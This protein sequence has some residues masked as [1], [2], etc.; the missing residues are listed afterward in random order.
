MPWG[1]NMSDFYSNELNNVSFDQHNYTKYGL[2]Y[3][4]LLFQQDR[5][6]L[7]A[8]LLADWY[9]TNKLVGV[10]VEAMSH[11]AGYTVPCDRLF[12]WLKQYYGET[13]PMPDTDK[14]RVI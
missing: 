11:G 4:H 6:P 1:R 2:A 13:S 5:F 9:G 12:S 8:Y 14:Q 10:D 7:H 3:W